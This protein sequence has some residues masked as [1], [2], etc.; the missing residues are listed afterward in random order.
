MGACPFQIALLSFFE[1]PV[2]LFYLPPLLTRHGCVIRRPAD[3]LRPLA[4][5]PAVAVFRRAVAVQG[6]AF[7]HMARAAEVDLKLPASK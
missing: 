5:R 2:H 6:E 7:V 4:Q 1:A 3:A